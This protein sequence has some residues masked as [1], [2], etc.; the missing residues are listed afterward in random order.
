MANARLENKE[1]DAIMSAARLKAAEGYGDG[2][3]KQQKY[4]GAESI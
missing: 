2:H 4:F 3:S 1:A